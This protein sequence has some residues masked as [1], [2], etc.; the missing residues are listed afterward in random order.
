MS[1]TLDEVT[2]ERRH[3]MKVIYLRGREALCGVCLCA[4]KK[5]GRSRE[6][7][8]AHRVKPGSSDPS[9]KRSP[10]SPA[11]IPQAIMLIINDKE[12]KGNS[13]SF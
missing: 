6:Q 8:T 1:S 3:T 2:I 10:N 9:T 4:G 13:L 11:H 12:L 5:N 7:I